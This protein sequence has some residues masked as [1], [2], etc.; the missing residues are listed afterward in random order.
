MSKKEYWQFYTTNVDF[1]LSWFEYAVLW[2][3]VIDPFAWKWDLLS[4][5][6]KNW[7][8]STF[9]YDI[10]KSNVSE[11]VA[12]NDSLLT[13]LKYEF[14]ITNPPYLGKNKASDETKDTYF[15]DNEF[16]DLYQLSILSLIWNSEEWI[17]IVPTNFL[18]ADNSKK[19][20]NKFF[21][22]YEI[23]KAKAFEEQVFADTTYNVIAIHYKKSPTTDIKPLNIEFIPS[24]KTLATTIEMKYGWS[25]AWSEISEI[26]N[27]PNHL[28]IKRL[29]EKNIPKWIIEKELFLWDFKVKKLFNTTDEFIT[30]NKDNII[31]IKAIDSDKS[32]KTPVWFYD[33]RNESSTLMISK[34]TSR[35]MTQLHIGVDLDI[36]EQ[37]ELMSDANKKLSE[38]REKYHWMF[39]TNFRDWNRKRLWYDFC[40][41][42]LNYIYEKKH[43]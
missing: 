39:M 9:G 41:N 15:K 11:T 7:A 5:A 33:R 17:I 43:L 24:G 19:I 8:I 18:S 1:I 4:W 30:K 40:Y 23:V 35:H 21:N 36:E 10:D 42:L 2:K 37:L 13:P 28:G 20:R 34:E 25:I 22:Q 14:V 16:E 26:S 31:L 6:D 27:T 38:L 12:Y 29:S 3:N 32:L